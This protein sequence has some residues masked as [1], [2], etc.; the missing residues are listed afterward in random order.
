MAAD[1]YTAHSQASE[2][3]NFGRVAGNATSDA[4]TH[5]LLSVG[6]S[7]GSAYL[8]LPL[9]RYCAVERRKFT[10]ARLTKS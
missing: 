1:K 2:S 6:Q 3:R 5:T 8:C 4:R 10:N 7:I 9:H